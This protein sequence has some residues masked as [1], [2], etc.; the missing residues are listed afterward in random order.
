MQTSGASSAASRGSGLEVSFPWELYG[1]GIL[2][3]VAAIAIWEAIKWVCEWYGLRRLGSVSESRGARRLRK[4]QQAVQQEVEKY[5]LDDFAAD[6]PWTALGE[7]A[8]LPRTSPTANEVEGPACGSLGRTYDPV[9]TPERLSRS[10]ERL[11]RT[12]TSSVGVQT[13][14]W[15]HGFREYPG[16]FIMSEH[17]DCVHHEPNCR[18]LRNAVTRRRQVTLCAYCRTR[19]MLYRQ[20]G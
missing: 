11:R 3:L 17:G 2:C 7:G 4:L 9:R 16:P 20:V 1:L 14:A 15:D 19:D 12:S 8:R 5:R 18:G 13:E 10:S 6:E